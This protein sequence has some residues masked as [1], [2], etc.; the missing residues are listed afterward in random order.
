MLPLALLRARCQR[1]LQ[2][3]S[4]WSS[5]GRKLRIPFAPSDK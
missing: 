2:A 3:S 5:L 1:V 4:R